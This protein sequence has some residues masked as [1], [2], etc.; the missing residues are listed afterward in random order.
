MMYPVVNQNPAAPAFWD[1]FAELPAAIESRLP[2][3]DKSLDAY[4]DTTF[5]SVIEEWELLTDT[6]LHKLESRLERVTGEIGT[7]YAEKLMLEKRAGELDI[8]ITSLEKSV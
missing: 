6:D 7:L 2:T 5:A 1:Q 8:L 3:M 4:F